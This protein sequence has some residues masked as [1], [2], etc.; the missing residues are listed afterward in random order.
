MNLHRSE[1]GMPLPFAY[2]SNRIIPASVH[3]DLRTV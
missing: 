2:E 3:V 1:D